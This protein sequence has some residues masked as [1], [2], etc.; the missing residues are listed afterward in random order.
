MENVKFQNLIT[1]V[2]S[3]WELNQI[4]VFANLS[5]GYTA[6]KL[7]E[8]LLELIKIKFRPRIVF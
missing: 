8:T 3:T 5:V 1:F 4:Y 2:H 6:D 7:S